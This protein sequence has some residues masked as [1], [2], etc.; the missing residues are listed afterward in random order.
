MAVGSGGASEKRGRAKSPLPLQKKEINSQENVLPPSPLKR[1]RSPGIRVVGGRIYDP[2]NGK[3]C[4]QVQLTISIKPFFR[5]LVISLIWV[6]EEVCEA[7]SDFIDLCF[8][9]ICLFLPQ[10]HWLYIYLISVLFT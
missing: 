9:D 5:F 1:N 3:T 2:V 10:L 7:R 6:L 4:H 8:Y